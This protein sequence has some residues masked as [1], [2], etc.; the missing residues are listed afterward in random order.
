[1]TPYQPKTTH[2]IDDLLETAGAVH[3][4]DRIV[5]SQIGLPAPTGLTGDRRK[6]EL[7]LIFDDDELLPSNAPNLAT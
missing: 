4:G 2:E 3:L 7:E 6:R 5:P 1:M